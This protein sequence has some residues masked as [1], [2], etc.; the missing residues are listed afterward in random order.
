VAQD[1]SNTRER[2]QRV[3]E[4]YRGIA[5]AL[6]GRGLPFVVLKGFTGDSLFFASAYRRAQYDLDLLLPRDAV[7]EARDALVELG[8]HPLESREKFPTDHH[9]VMVPK[10]GFEWRGDFF[11]PDIP[12]TVDLHFRLWDEATERFAAP[13][14]EQFFERR[15]TCSWDGLNVPSL[16]PC[17]A[18]AYHSLHL[19]RHLL[20]GSLRLAHVHEL[21]FFLQ[22]SVTDTAFWSE[23]KTLYPEPTRR[24][25]A[26]CFDLAR[27]WFGCR[28]SP[29]A[30]SEIA[31]LPA[32]VHYWLA[33]YSASPL[34]A[35]QHPNKDELWLHLGLLDH[36]PARLSVLR[37]RILPL[38]VPDFADTAYLNEGQI[39]RARRWR[40]R[41]RRLLYISSRALHHIKTLPGVLWHGTCWGWSR[42]N[43]GQLAPAYWRFLWAATFFNLGSFVFLVLYNLYLADFGFREDALGQFSSAMTLGSLAGS[44]PAGIALR[45]FGPR[46]ALAGCFAGL[47]LFSLARIVFPTSAPLLAFSF[48]SGVAFA[49]F[50]V[51]VAPAIAQLSNDSTRP[52]AFSIFFSVGIAL[53]IA[54][55]QLAGHLP[56]LLGSKRAALYA[57][58]VLIALAVVPALS[59]RMAPVASSTERSYPSGSFVRRFLVSIFVWS[60]AAGAFS[61]FFNVFFAQRL[62][63]SVTQVGNIYSL[64]QAAQVV[65]ILFAPHVLARLGLTAGV[66]LSQFLCG[67]ALLGLAL[68]SH[69]GLWTAG[70][71]YA[72]YLGFHFMGEPGL[73]SLLM[74]HAAPHERSGASALN[75][76][77]TFAGQAVAVAL[78]GVVVARSGYTPV[79]TAAAGLSALAALLVWRMA[80]DDPHN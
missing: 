39:T 22:R 44:V 64:G 48:L 29:T 40:S 70:L 47:A 27:R 36:W 6:E 12:V 18:L 33:H 62:N 67:L 14:W 68:A 75:F 49:I 38:S 19:L 58:C 54:G 9:P 51:T 23:W 56:D 25:Q 2:Q 50:A 24:S 13:G 20:R 77:A 63:A 78:A 1:L 72:G 76:L 11:D 71:C 30:E 46:A 57:A 37:R 32:P 61:P 41:L 28:L 45:R 73:F 74:N 43:T 4:A 7:A 35:L 31:S 26:V 53:G 5:K 66:A 69:V 65:A 55:G 3:R 80:T 52:R 59:L 60:M 17:D 15:T 34:Q 8:Y 42:S 21:A 79:F 10:T 16:A